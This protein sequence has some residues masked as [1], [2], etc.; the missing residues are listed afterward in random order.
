MRKSAL[1]SKQISIIA[2]K[3]TV[4]PSFVVDVGRKVFV[5]SD[6]PVDDALLLCSLVPVGPGKVIPVVFLFA[7]LV[8]ARRKVEAYPGI[9]VVR[10]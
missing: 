2:F 3:L 10:S 9:D 4:V 5:V 1:I 7:V 6:N 8:P